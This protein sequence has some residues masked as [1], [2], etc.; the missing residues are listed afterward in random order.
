VEEVGLGF[1]V[2]LQFEYVPEERA[3]AVSATHVIGEEK[4]PNLGVDLWAYYTAFRLYAAAHPR[5]RFQPPRRRPRAG[6][7]LDERFYRSVV[8]LYE[9][10]KVRGHRS[11]AVEL[12]QR[13]DANP[14]TVR[15]WVYRGRRLPAETG[16]GSKE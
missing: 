15:S 14:A 9:E 7:P 4:G 10:L 2:E 12:A 16:K 11:P 3:H 5:Q 13:M 1:R 8:E 6:Q